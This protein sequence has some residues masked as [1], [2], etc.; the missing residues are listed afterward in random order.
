MNLADV[1]DAD[2]SVTVS[3]KGIP[4]SA[5]FLSEQRLDLLRFTRETAKSLQVLS[6]T[7]SALDGIRSKAQ[8]E[9]G[10]RM[11]KAA[12]NVRRMQEKEAAR[13]RK[14]MDKGSRADEDDDDENG[15]GG[16]DDDDDDDDDGGEDEAA[17]ADIVEVKDYD[18]MLRASVK[19]APTALDVEKEKIVLE[20]KSVLGLSE[21]R[22]DKK[23]KAGAKGGDDDDDEIEVEVN[24]K[25]RENDLK[26]PYSTTFFEDPYKCNVCNHTFSKA[27]LDALFKKERTVKCPVGGCRNKDMSMKQCEPDIDMTTKVESFLR[28]RAKAEAAKKKREEMQATDDDDT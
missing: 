11:D 8:S 1:L 6:T 27:S 19:S 15:G 13:R 5:A 2:G 18:A 26:C 14:A 10:V 7:L 28:R 25:Q 17:A 21:G 3:L 23:R 20:L 4:D 24:D 9:H 12:A 16:G 22:D